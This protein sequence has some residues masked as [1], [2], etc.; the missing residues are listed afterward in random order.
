[1]T[2]TF[3]TYW[4]IAFA[5]AIHTAV[6]QQCY[7]PNGSEAPEKPC[8]SAEGSA[9]CPDKW[10]CLDN[11]LCHYPPDKLFGRYSCTDKSWKA[12]GCPSNMCTYDMKA[13][14]GESITQ[15]A[16]HDNQWCCNAD[17][18]HVNCCKE[19]PA[20]R[21]FFDLADGKAYATVG[22]STASSAPNLAT[23][24]GKADGADAGPSQTPTPSASNAPPPTSAPNT[25][26]SAS[27][28][29]KPTTQLQTSLSSGTAGIVTV[30]RTQVVTPPA[31]TNT[32]LPPSTPGKSSSKLPVIVGCAV[33]IPLALALVGI[34]FWLLRKRSQQ[35]KANH[36]RESKPPYADEIMTDGSPSPAYGF[37]GG[38]KYNHGEKPPLTTYKSSGAAHGVPELAGQSIGPSAPVSA[39]NGRA[40]LDS[41][42]AFVPGAAAA[43]A[44]HLVGLGGG[45]GHANPNPLAQHTPHS[46]WGSAPTGYSPNRNSEAV[47]ASVLG[48]YNQNGGAGSRPVSAVAAGAP[49]GGYIPYRPDNLTQPP[50]AEMSSVTT[51]PAAELSSVQTPPAV[52]LSTVRTPPA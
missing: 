3:C 44:P 38:A 12:E 7:Y 45:N 2:R 47:P 31:S 28:D 5:L 43:H 25:T 34:I 26:P 15:C 21:P 40:E 32:S 42:A 33:G 29:A 35:A 27:V 9:C 49:P 37:A 18:E 51:P 16:D 24:T 4:R 41:G 48:S 30:V 46:S 6:A 1:M 8:S 50:P 19:S 20:P 39:I 14:G 13:A 52:E 23:I 11:G 17:A 36:G 10:E 22:S